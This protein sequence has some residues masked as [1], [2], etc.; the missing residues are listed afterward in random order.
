MDFFFFARDMTGQ[1]PTVSA[2]DPETAALEGKKRAEEE[3]AENVV[4]DAKVV[5]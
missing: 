3:K 2:G 5:I 4:A 1:T